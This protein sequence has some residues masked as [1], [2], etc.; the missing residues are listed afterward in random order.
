MDSKLSAWLL[1]MLAIVV[2]VLIAELILDA[3][4]AHRPM[5][6]GYEGRQ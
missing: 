4:H 6:D 3:W 1:D 2:G 5:L